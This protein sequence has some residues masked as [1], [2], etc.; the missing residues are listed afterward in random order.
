MSLQKRI[1]EYI[2]NKKAVYINEVRDQILNS[3]ND[4][5]VLRTLKN[6]E[7]SGDV[8]SFNNEKGS[9]VR[10]TRNGRQK[11]R[12]LNL[13]SDTNIISTH[14]DGKWRMVIL[15]VPEN[16]KEVRN[17]LRYILKKARFVCLKNSVWI[18]PYP[19]EYMLEGMKRDLELGNEIM[20]SVT[21]YLD[22]ATE[23]TFRE[24]YWSV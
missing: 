10:V 24:K 22:P 16:D 6:L 19:F 8:M 15:D 2:L 4:Y 14:W 12:S 1:L 13:S 9:Y 21:E 3:T 18:S 7:K 23:K 5:S 11:L 17:A 20:I